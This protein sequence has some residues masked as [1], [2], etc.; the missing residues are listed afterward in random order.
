MFILS[1]DLSNQI[2]MMM[3]FISKL[4]GNLA[5]KRVRGQSRHNMLKARIIVIP[6]NLIF[7]EGQK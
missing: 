1:N 4:Y 7:V 3:S 2:V 5:A 6:K